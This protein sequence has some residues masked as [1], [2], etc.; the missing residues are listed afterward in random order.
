MGLRAALS[1]VTAPPK[2]RRDAPYE[3]EFDEATGTFTYHY[4]RPQSESTRARLSAASDNRA[5]TEAMRLGVPLIYFRGIASGQSTP[6]APTFLTRDDPVREVVAF[7]VALPVADTTPAGVTSD[8]VTRRYATQEAQVRLH[9]HYFRQ[10]VLRAY[11][12][13]CAVCA[14]REAPLLQA[15][16]II[17]DRDP[18]GSAAVINGIALC[19]IHHLAYDRNLLGIAPDG[20]VHIATRLLEEIDGPMLRVGL[21]GFHRSAITRAQGPS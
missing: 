16:H 13:R 4:R 17:E 14:L 12:T 11:R 10:R 1:L 18:R 20:V 2:E 6:V 15:A 5:M 7:Q 9:Q 19:A 21:Q 8:D 3:D